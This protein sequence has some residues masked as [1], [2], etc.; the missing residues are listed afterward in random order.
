MTLNITFLRFIILI[1]L[2]YISTLCVVTVQPTVCVFSLLI[3]VL[4]LTPFNIMNSG[5]LCNIIIIIVFAV[6]VYIMIFVF[7]ILGGK[8][9]F[10]TNKIFMF[11]TILTINCILF[12]Q[13]K[14]NFNH[15]LVYTNINFGELLIWMTLITILIVI[16]L[17][18]RSILEFSTGIRVFKINYVYTICFVRFYF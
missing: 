16:L 15:N 3:V 2:I 14:N 8:Y 13:E 18:L 7:S 12:Y 11:V 17:Y 6:G 9:T 1:C 4:M 5:V 10:K